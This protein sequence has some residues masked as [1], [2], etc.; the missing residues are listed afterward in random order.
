RR[1]PKRLL[2]GCLLATALPLWAALWHRGLGLVAAQY[3]VTT[4]VVWIA[5]VAVRFALDVV[6]ARVVGRAPASSRTLLVGPAEERRALAA[7]RAFAPRGEHAVLRYVD[8]AA[9]AHPT[10]L[11]SLIERPALVQRYRVE[12]V[13][14]CGHIPEAGLDTMVAQAM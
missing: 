11:G 10:A 8:S 3:A 14:I 1:A 5:L 12:W 2:A 9:P 4:A 7:R 13:V 6:D